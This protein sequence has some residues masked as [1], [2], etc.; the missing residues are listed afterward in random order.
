MAADEA[1]MRALATAVTRG[2]FVQRG[3]AAR[4]FDLRLRHATGVAK[5]TH[6]AA[7]CK[8][9]LEAKQPIVLTGWHRD[10]YDI[11]LREL[12]A[13][14]PVLYTGS[15][16]PRQKRRAV[17]AFTSGASNLFILSLRSG[18]GLN[19]LQ[20]RS[21]TI[22]HGELDWS[23]QVHAQCTA[24]L[25]RPGQEQVVDEIYLVADGGADPAIVG[26]LGLQSSQ[27][28]ALL[29]PLAAAGDQP[30]DSTRIRQL[31]ELY[32]AGKSHLAAPPAPKVASP[33][34][35]TEQMGLGL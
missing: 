15:E 33:Q 19:G 17:E 5:A 25:D 14:N 32:L 29:D 7:F 2:S 13:Y 4:E 8:I 28:A 26:V 23:P 11:W 1:T 6:V 30:Q 3:Q 31:A 9:L 21:H 27:S 20:F 12:A 22:V 10:V 24:R 18:A 16:S 35:Q 34:P